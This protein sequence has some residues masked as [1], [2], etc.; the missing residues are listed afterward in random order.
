MENILP[1]SGKWMLHPLDL[2]QVRKYTS[3]FDD[4]KAIEVDTQNS[5]Y[6]N[7]VT[8]K[9][10]ENSVR[11]LS[12]TYWL[13]KR[14][15]PIS[16]K[17]REKAI[18]RA[19]A[20]LLTLVNGKLAE[21]EDI[22]NLLY[23][24][25]NEIGIISTSSFMGNVEIITSKEG[26]V[27]FIGVKTKRKS[28]GKWQLK[29]RVM[30]TSFESQNVP[31]SIEIL[32]KTYEES[33]QVEKGSALLESTLEIEDD[34]TEWDI[35]GYGKQKSYRAC[36]LVNGT[37]F[38]KQVA[39]RDLDLVDGALNLN[40]HRIF[41]MGALWPK[42]IPADSRRYEELL[43][44]AIDA[45]MNVLAI[46]DGHESHMFYSIADRLGLLVLHKE[47]NIEFSSHP[48][49]AYVDIDS[50]KKFKAEKDGSDFKS[51]CM[52]AINLERCV[53]RARS[54]DE[55]RGVLYDNLTSTVTED[56]KWEPSH[57][58]ARRFFSDLV[59]I[60]YQEDGKLKILA[61]NDSAKDETMDISIKFIRYD[62]EK[63]KKFMH[64]VFVPAHSHRE[65]RTVDLR[66][67]DVEH[68]FVYVKLRT[69]EVHRE[70]TLL[71]SP[72]EKCAFLPPQLQL[73]VQKAGTS[74]Y[75]FRVKCQKPAFAVTLEVENVE[76]R[77]SDNCFEVRPSS[78]KM[79][80]F[81]PYKDVD[82]ETI[83][84]NVRVYDIYS[85]WV[86]KK[87]E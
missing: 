33:F 53:L 50:L 10:V 27:K 3:A 17:D 67:I 83:K 4:G 7:L 69:D 39:F 34:V 9:L 80:I 28:E 51:K 78:E 11:F 45:N 86:G 72:I 25:D 57:Y 41:H 35:K 14:S 62:G 61:S 54:S 8:K 1:L 84:K 13:L 37:M 59:P 15:F 6:T 43:K 64:T 16:L 82:I 52:N 65:V 73:T 19:P 40:G 46:E 79:V 20:S 31:L 5:I 44:S 70:L 12:G 68:E 74:S 76:G 29:I 24:G 42:G 55:T 23:D 85:D 60:M 47:K 63:R 36:I 21:S 18:L 30:Y 66:K 71:L 81:T 77:F 22:T 48:S 38:E 32:G 58:L 56:G 49:Y 2:S 75:S 26:V 87:E